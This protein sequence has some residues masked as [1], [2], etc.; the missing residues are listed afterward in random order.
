LRRL[1]DRPIRHRVESLLFATL[2]VAAVP[3]VLQELLPTISGL[4]FLRP[5]HYLGG[6][7]FPL[8]LMVAGVLESWLHL[9]AEQCKRALRRMAIILP[10]TWGGL[11]VVFLLFSRDAA[12]QFSVHWPTFWA[13]T[14]SAG[15][16]ILLFATTMFHPKAQVL[17][18][19]TLVLL[20]LT[21]AWGSL[22][23]RPASP[24]DDLFPRTDVI[25]AL[26]ESDARVGGTA[27]MASWPLAG[28][29]IPALYAPGT[30]VLNRTQAFLDQ[31][32]RDPLLHRRASVGTLL[33][34]KE[35]IQ[36]AYAPVR[37]DL[38]IVDV[39]DAGLVLFRDNGAL[40]RYRMAHAV[41]GD[42][43]ALSQLRPGGLPVVPGVALP[44]VNGPIREAIRLADVPRNNALDLDVET[45]HPGILIVAAAWYPGWR[46]EVNGNPVPV[47][48][49]DGALSGVE[50]RAGTHTVSFRYQSATLRWGALISLLFLAFFLA[51][52]YWATRRPKRRY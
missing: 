4:R 33:L 17:L 27:R 42:A 26:Q 44:P 16:L 12:G 2:L 7:S 47:F 18:A 41:E 52:A 22:P 29:Q 31:V 38:N 48:P 15:A 25:R 45:S 36:G 8:A 51:G 9:N 30:V 20:L 23:S 24:R 5:A 1:I 35:D 40:P 6:L 11:L 37:E 3:L 21:T 13:F 10:P 39:F 28:N 49:V 46:A 14:L 43:A 19:G 34:Q 32:D 50:L